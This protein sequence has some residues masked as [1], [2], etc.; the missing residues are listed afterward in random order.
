MGCSPPVEDHWLRRTHGVCRVRFWKNENYPPSGLVNF[1]Y[2]SRP[3]VL[4]NLHNNGGFERSKLRFGCGFSKPKSVRNR[5]NAESGPF[6]TE[7]GL[8]IRDDADSRGC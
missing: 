3:L 5:S 8:S 2:F 1:R 6:G 4:H 7:K